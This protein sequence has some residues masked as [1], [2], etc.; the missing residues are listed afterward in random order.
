MTYRVRIA[1]SPT[2]FMHIGTLRT[3][4]Y[5]Y[6]LAKKNNGV[7]VCRVED[8]DQDRFVEGAIDAIYDGMNWLGLKFDE[9]PREGGD[10]GPYVQSERKQ[11]HLEVVEELIKLD[12]AYKCF[13]TKDRLTELRDF[14]QKLGKP[15]GY[16]GLCRSLSEEEVSQRIE[17]GEEYVVR[18]KIPKDTTIKFH[19]EVRGDVEFDSNTLDDHIIFKSDGLATAQLAIPLDDHDMG[20]TQVIRGEE[21]LPSTP[22][23]VLLFDF[24]GWE[25]PKYAHLSNILRADGSGKKL[26]KRDG[27]AFVSDYISAGFL[28]EATISY[29]PMLG[30]N[31]GTD[32]DIFTL[33]ELIEQFSLDRVQKSGSAFDMAKFEWVN[34]HFIRALTPEALLDRMMPFFEKEDFF[35]PSISRDELL[36]LVKEIQPRMKTLKDGAQGSSWYFLEPDFDMSLLVNEKFAL[37]MD[38]AKSILSDIRDVLDGVNDFEVEKIKEVLQEYVTTKGYKNGQVLWPLRVA[39]TGLP[40]SPGAYEVASLLGKEKTLQRLSD[41]IDK[42]LK[43]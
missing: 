32:Q 16:D 36:K 3:I 10:F 40:F 13:C 38:L 37:D 4:L 29:I 24:L 8:T 6:F 42:L 1:P 31:P 18:M 9:G 2:G 19:D 17:K 23:Q 41:V 28:P 35:D 22:R 34:G 30:W 26:S 7:F 39:L 21:W 12:K 33:D 25:R 14:Q 27:N 11:R 5:N 20:I 43:N 15:T